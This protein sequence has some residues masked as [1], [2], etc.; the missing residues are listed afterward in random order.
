[1]MSEKFYK[2]KYKLNQDQRIF[3]N[4]RDNKIIIYKNIN[5]FRNKQKFH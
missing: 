2:I 1:M 4:K 5:R 3:Y